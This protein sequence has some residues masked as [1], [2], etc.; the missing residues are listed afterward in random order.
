MNRSVGVRTVILSL[1]A[2]LT[3]AGPVS[4]FGDPAYAVIEVTPFQTW[5]NSGARTIRNDGSVAGSAK[6]SGLNLLL[7]AWWRNGNLGVVGTLGGLSATAQDGN[8][9]G[10]IVGSGFTGEGEHAFYWSNADGLID[11]GTIDGSR[12]TSE[13]LGIN[14]DGVAVGWSTDSLDR[15]IAFCWTKTSGMQ[16]LPSLPNGERTRAYDINNAGTIVGVARDDGPGEYGIAWMDG[17]MI[18]L[19]HLGDGYTEARAINEHG[20]ITGWSMYFGLDHGFLWDNGQMV[21]IHFDGWELGC[22]SYPYG[23]N[24]FTEIVGALDDCDRSFAFVWQPGEMRLLNEIAPP[25]SRWD[26]YVAWDIND[27]GQIVGDGFPDPVH[28]PFLIRGYV[29]SPVYPTFSLSSLDD[30]QAGEQVTLQADGVDAGAQVH[31]VYGRFGGGTLIPD[32][33]LTI[34]A[35]QIDDPITLGTATADETGIAQ[36]VTLINEGASGQ[37]VLLQAVVQSE[38]RISNLIDV[39]IK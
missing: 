30:Y 27:L 32:C 16:A 39:T 20:Q 7:A 13:A 8:E 2:T 12:G 10:Q 3:L 21:N 29:M 38:C 18:D 28:R 33:D 23:I 35:V 14:N 37:S 34:N 24:N 1:I 11:L 4:G 5:G 25:R 31:F 17:K 15:Q 22:K 36:L 19:G 9:T 26:M 6:H